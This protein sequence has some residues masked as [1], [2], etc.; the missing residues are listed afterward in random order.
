MVYLC[1]GHIWIRED[2]GDSSMAMLSEVYVVRTLPFLLNSEK[3][4]DMDNDIWKEVYN[5]VKTDRTSQ[6]SINV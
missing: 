2:H 5:L 4:M 3:K 6:F 1:S